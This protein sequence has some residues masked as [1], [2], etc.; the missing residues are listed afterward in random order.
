VEYY[1]DLVQ[2]ICIT[3]KTR[4][5]ELDISDIDKIKSTNTLAGY[6]IQ[7]KDLIIAI[8]PGGGASWGK[9]A[10]IKHWPAIKFAQLA[11][12]VSEEFSAKILILGDESER[13]IVDIIIKTAQCP[14]I[15][16][17]GK[18]T[19]RELISIINKAG[20]LIANDGGPLH[21]A[22]ALGKKT[23]SFFGP[24]DPQVYGPYPPDRMRHIVLRKNLECSPCYAGFRLSGC[25]R[26]RE[27]LE[28]IDVEEA[29]EAVAKLL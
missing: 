28:K 27:C 9:E 2:F 15:N 13:P 7:D 21:I 8:A 1:L 23:V 22:V 4:N 6:G 19:L 25:Q 3:P 24:V 17:V 26:N 29:Q 16:L 5:L 11:N 18:T 10:K 12:K 14:M 20:I